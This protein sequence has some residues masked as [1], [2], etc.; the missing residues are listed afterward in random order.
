MNQNTTIY[1]QVAASVRDESTLQR[2]L[3]PLTQIKDSYPKLILTLDE[4]P[5]ADYNGIL[6][7][8]VLDWLLKD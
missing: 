8:N 5:D 7:T 2:E 4:D 1:I 3:T 6:R